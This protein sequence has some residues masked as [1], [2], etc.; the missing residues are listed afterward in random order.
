MDISLYKLY[1]SFLLKVV[2]YPFDLQKAGTGLKNNSTPVVKD[3]QSGASWAFEVGGDST[4][5]PILVEDLQYPGHMVIEVCM[6]A[7]ST[8]CTSNIFVISYIF[9]FSL[10]MI[11]DDSIRFLEI[12]EV[13][14][15]LELTILHGV[16]EKRSGN[17]WARYVVEVCTFSSFLFFLK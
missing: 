13:I 8:S 12:A 3:S 14:H 6:L 16:M 2:Y 9:C 15:G 17:T 7:V 4:V 5:C 10:Q 11:C 1:L